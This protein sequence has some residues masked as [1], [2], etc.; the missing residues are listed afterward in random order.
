MTDQNL[1]STPPSSPSQLTPILQSINRTLNDTDPESWSSRA[2]ALQTLSHLAQTLSPSLHPTLLQYLP[3]C[4]L[5]EQ[6]LDLRSLITGPATELIVT[7]S[8]VLGHLSGFYQILEKWFPAI[9]KLC[10]SGVKLMSRQGI[11]CGIQVFRTEFPK[12]LPQLTNNNNHPKIRLMS[13]SSLTV[14]VRLWE[15]VTLDNVKATIERAIADRDPDCRAEGRKL[16]LACE[17]RFGLRLELDRSVKKSVDRQRKDVLKEWVKGGQMYKSLKLDELN[18]TVYGLNPTDE[19]EGAKEVKVRTGSRIR[20]VNSSRDRRSQLQ[21]HKRR[22]WGDNGVVVKSSLPPFSKRASTGENVKAAS[23]MEVFDIVTNEIKTDPRNIV[24]DDEEMLITPRNA[25][26]EQPTAPISV[27]ESSEED[28]MLITPHN[29]KEE[30]QTVALPPIDVAENDLLITSH[31]AQEEE[32][33]PA[34]TRNH[35]TDPVRSKEEHPEMTLDGTMAPLPDASPKSSGHK[36]A[37]EQVQTAV[38][39]PPPVSNDTKED[40][41]M[42]PP[43]PPN[44]VAFEQSFVIKATPPRNPKRQLIPQSPGDF[45]SYSPYVSTSN[46]RLVEDDVIELLRYESNDKHAGIKGLQQLLRQGDLERCDDVVD[47]IMDV[48]SRMT[49]SGDSTSTDLSFSEDNKL[50]LL[51]FQ[52]FRTV[53]K[54]HQY[55]LDQSLTKTLPFLLQALINSPLEIHHTIERTLSL[56]IKRTTHPTS[57]LQYILPAL[58]TT[59]TDLELSSLYL[60]SLRLLNQLIPRLPPNAV[61]DT[62]AKIMPGVVQAA[63]SNVVEYRK[64]AIFCCVEGYG[65]KAV[66]DWLGELTEVQRRLVR[67]YVDKKRPVEERQ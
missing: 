18:K 14:A 59:T 66:E 45:I 57:V 4:P 61:E 13:I 64:T 43:R 47:C 26:E 15:N 42:S 34:V 52:A 21:A 16:Y 20:E 36:P 65:T 10:M 46:T 38:T 41:L 25:P 33:T 23:P 49:N 40:I 3:K 35:A 48:M 63:N 7:L 22:F 53:L 28:E 29:S 8:R 9:Q 54:Y 17:G 19:N 58:T 37:D 51:Y 6:L 39:S 62:L 32:P 5:S 44:R 27:K 55:F 31:S 24:E 60:P 50:N 67:V 30:N 2:T 1:P 56:I 11:Q 12:L